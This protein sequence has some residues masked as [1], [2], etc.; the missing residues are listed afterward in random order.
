MAWSKAH[1]FQLSASLHQGALV[2]NYPFDSC[3]TQVNDITTRLDAQQLQHEAQQSRTMK[4]QWLH[5]LKVFDQFLMWSR[6]L[7]CAGCCALLPHTR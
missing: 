4:A 7:P 3:D 1:N 6:L 5:R 2:A